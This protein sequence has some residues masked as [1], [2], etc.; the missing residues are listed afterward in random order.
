[1]IYDRE[2]VLRFLFFSPSEASTKQAM[3][4]KML[5]LKKDYLGTVNKKHLH[6]IYPFVRTDSTPSFLVHAD[7]QKIQSF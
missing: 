5:T 6:K 7:T 2:F 3:A 1:M 4:Q